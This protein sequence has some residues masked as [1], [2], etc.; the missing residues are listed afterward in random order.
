MSCPVP[1]L[2]VV[3]VPCPGH[4]NYGCILHRVQY[5]CPRKVRS[6]ALDPPS[7]TL[8]TRYGLGGHGPAAIVLYWASGPWPYSFRPSTFG[9]RRCS[10]PAVELGC[11]EHQ[12]FFFFVARVGR[13]VF[14][15]CCSALDDCEHSSACELVQDCW[16]LP[17]SKCSSLGKSIA[18][19]RL[20]TCFSIAPTRTTIP[21][22]H[23]RKRKKAFTPLHFTGT[24][25]FT[26]NMTSSR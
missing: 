4:T 1:L 23:H 6:T 26:Q 9:L 13:Q 8:T 19:C 5:P 15:I 21:K 17:S 12:L 24:P 7:D 20:F 22:R 2:L 10:L 25:F 3:H 18:A 14:T 16:I 11:I